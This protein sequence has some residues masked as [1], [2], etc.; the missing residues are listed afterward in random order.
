MRQSALT[1]IN[2]HDELKRRRVDSFANEEEVKR[3]EA[4]KESRYEICSEDEDA[5]EMRIISGAY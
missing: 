5:L 2:E 3:F 4:G 1:S